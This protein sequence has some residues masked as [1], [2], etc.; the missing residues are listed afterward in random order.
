MC[1]SSSCLI[2]S[3]RLCRLS[4][5]DLGLSS[6]CEQSRWQLRN[7]P[8]WRAQEADADGSANEP[9]S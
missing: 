6:T 9:A 3:L 4:R 5:A 1:L 2:H 7:T 8:A